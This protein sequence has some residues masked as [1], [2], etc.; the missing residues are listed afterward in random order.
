MEEPITSFRAGDVFRCPGDYPMVIIVERHY[1]D[2][3]VEYGFG[4][5]R[6]NNPCSLY[7]DPFRTYEEMLD[8][9]NELPLTYVGHCDFQIPKFG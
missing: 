2:M 8:H 1:D 3:T 6:H 4:G 7:T 9:I 5:A